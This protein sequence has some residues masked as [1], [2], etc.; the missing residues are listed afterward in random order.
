MIAFIQQE[1]AEKVEEIEAKAEEEFKAAKE[2]AEA[3]NEAKTEFL[4]NMRHDFR[5]PFTGILGLTELMMVQET[6]PEKQENLGYI[7]E[8]AKALLEHLNE[9]MEFIQIESGQLP[10][11]EKSFDLC[12]LL[13]DIYK[14]MLP[15]VEN[16]QL[17]FQF[18]IDKT[19][20]HYVIGDTVRLQRILMNL[21][22]NAIKFTDKGYIKLAAKVLRYIDDKNVIVQFIIEDTGI[23]IPKEK[24]HI[25]FERFNRLTSSYSG[26]YSG[27]GFGLRI[28]KQ[29]LDEINGECDL[30]STAGEGAC[31]QVAISY[32]LPYIHEGI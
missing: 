11:L 32:K 24:Q 5:T 9:I 29:F 10:I 31:F 25:I 19:L 8:S 23:G 20:P 14:M 1:A 12:A 6:D 15:S 26:I 16:K 7:A 13:D 3:A 27:K 28:V 22:S 4:R 30:K 2:T 17:D 18:I 21:L